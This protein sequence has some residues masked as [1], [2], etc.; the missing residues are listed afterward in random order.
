[1]REQEIIRKI[2]NMD[3]AAREATHDAMERRTRTAHAA[4]KKKKE[5]TDTFISMARNRVDVIRNTEV[6]YAAAQLAEG[7][8]QREAAA[9]RM[10]GQYEA[11]R[12]EWVNAIVSRVTDGDDLL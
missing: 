9:K 2:I 7:N 5:V 12:E 10:D 8:K 4:E 3:K 6:Q 1:M 11:H